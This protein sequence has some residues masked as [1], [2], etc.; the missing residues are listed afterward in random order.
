MKKLLLGLSALS[1]LTACSQGGVDSAAS[2]AKKVVETA[3]TKTAE[4][5][6]FHYMFMDGFS[7]EMGKFV[8]LNIGENF[9]TAEPKINAVFKAYDGNAAPTDID[10]QAEI[11]EAGWKQVLVTQ[12]GVTDGVLAGQQLLAVFDEEKN[13]VTY[14][15]RIKCQSGAAVTDWQNTPC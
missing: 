2:D 12:N 8:G 9:A 14:G 3:V 10:M 13:L 5:G 11:V 6:E 15:M 7:Q 1:V 4:T